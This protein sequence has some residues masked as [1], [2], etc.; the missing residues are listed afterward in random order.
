MRASGRWDRADKRQQEK[1]KRFFNMVG[2]KRLLW[3]KQPFADTYTDPGFVREWEAWKRQQKGVRSYSS[4]RAIL[5]DMFQFYHLVI[6]TMLLYIIFEWFYLYHYNPVIISTGI[7]S[8]SLL[9]GHRRVRWK[10]TIIIIFCMLTASP[11]LKSLAKSTSSDSIWTLSAWITIFYLISICSVKSK[12]LPTNL[13]I[14]NV[15][16]LSSRLET[17]THVFCFLLVCVQVNIL[18]PILEKYLFKNRIRSGLVSSIAA[19]HGTVYY[20]VTRLLGVS[21]SVL[22]GICSL[23]F[24]FLTPFY[25]IFWQKHYYKGHVMLHQWDAKK[26][27]LD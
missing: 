20:F 2:W 26:P 21:T 7:T 22:L 15:V 14:S 4:Y 24:L 16:V 17:S 12:I 9:I 3:Q 6:N 19:T 25:Y 18:L 23:M 10:S 8:S 13:L 11:V 5:V 27:I 1:E